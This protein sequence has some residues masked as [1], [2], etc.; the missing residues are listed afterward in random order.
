MTQ[1]T[2]LKLEENNLE[3]TIPS[4]FSELKSIELLDLGSNNLEGTIP[5]SFSK[6]RSIEVLYLDENNLEGT[7][8]SSFSELKSVELLG[9]GGNNLEGTIPS[10]FSE[11]K[12][13]EHLYLN[14]N[15]LSGMLDFDMFLNFKNLT[16]LDLSSNNLTL[17]TKANSNDTLQQFE[18]LDLSSCNLRKFP[19]F[20][21]N[22]NKLSFLHLSHNNLQGLIP[23]WFYNASIESLEFINLSENFLVGFEQSPIVLP[24]SKLSSLD[25]GNNSLQGSLPIP[26]PSTTIYRVQR[27]FIREMSSLLICNLSSLE[28]LDLSY[29][30]LSGMLPPCLGNFSSPLLVLQLRSNDFHGTIP[31]T[32]SKGS[33]LKMI[34]LSENQLQGQ[35]PRSMA[36]CMMLELPS[37]C[38]SGNLPT[39]YF[40]YWNAMKVV[41]A[42]QLIYMELDITSRDGSFNGTVLCTVTVTNKGLNLEYDK[43]QDLFTDIYIGAGES[44][45]TTLEWPMSELIRNPRIMEKAQA[46]VRQVLIGK[47]KL[48]GKDMQQLDFAKYDQRN[49]K[50]TSSCSLTNKRIQGKM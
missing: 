40:L 30:N 50:I 36:N 41:G 5:S 39:E 47:R 49:F 13:I 15:N 46:E 28:L 23:K 22:Q 1:L 18:T 14:E 42:N 10:S 43:I 31:K 37:C 8:P 48:E 4:S 34:D 17:L 38:F 35:L 20:L 25:L 6:L 2:F 29:N 32:W 9:L 33:G 7:I 44:S 12:S 19:D 16:S 27:N 24:W 11:L 3:G 21:R 26:P 45:A